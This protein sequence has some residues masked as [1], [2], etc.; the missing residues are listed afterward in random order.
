ML[1]PAL[2]AVPPTLRAAFVLSPERGEPDF[3]PHAA[4]CDS[5]LLRPD[6]DSQYSLTQPR[7][8][9]LVRVRPFTLDFD[10]VSC[11]HQCVLVV[12]MTMEEEVVKLRRPTANAPGPFI[13][14]WSL[15]H[16]LWPRVTPLTSSE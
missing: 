15:H 1:H 11:V 5:R 9:H 2:F 10:L 7:H 4:A 8:S 13:Q 14:S 3:Y 12:A 6:H 16:Y